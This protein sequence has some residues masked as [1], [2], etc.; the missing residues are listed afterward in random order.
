[1]KYKYNGNKD[2]I[3][4]RGVTFERGKV[5]DLSDNPDLSEKISV[6]PYFSEVK[7]RKRKS[8]TNAQDQD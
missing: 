5:V 6:L 8:D 1:M 3:T 2:A 7:S 4:L